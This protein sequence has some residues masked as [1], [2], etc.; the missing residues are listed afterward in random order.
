M[1]MYHII[2]VA[3]NLVPNILL[4]YTA[5]IYVCDTDSVRDTMDTGADIFNF[6]SG[7]Y[8]WTGVNFFSLLPP[9]PLF[10][11]GSCSSTHILCEV[12]NTKEIK[13]EKFQQRRHLY[14][15]SMLTA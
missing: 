11:H 4:Y 10:F 5:Y 3:E 12:W 8:F 6:M 13:K 9:S 7:I 15:S 1:V 2:G 14:F